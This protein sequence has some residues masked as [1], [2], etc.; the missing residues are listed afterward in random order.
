MT[1]VFV[2]IFILCFLEY[3][4]AG[5]GLGSVAMHVIHSFRRTA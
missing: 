5:N 2:K 1:A 4:H 3:Q